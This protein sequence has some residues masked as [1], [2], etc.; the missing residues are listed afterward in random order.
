MR[1]SGSAQSL[2]QGLHG[3]PNNNNNNSRLRESRSSKLM[4]SRSFEQ[5]IN[6]GS[7]VARDDEILCSNSN[8]H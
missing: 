8:E 7:P 5:L 4:E 3:Q 6:L 1:T 2:L